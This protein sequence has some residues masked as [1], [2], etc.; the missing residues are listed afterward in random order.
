MK[1]WS[2]FK[3]TTLRETLKE[4]K[5]KKIIQEGWE[6]QNRY[7][8]DIYRFQHHL[9]NVSETAVKKILEIT[10]DFRLKW[11]VSSN[12]PL[13]DNPYKLASYLRSIYSFSR[14]QNHREHHHLWERLKFLDYWRG[15]IPAM[16]PEVLHHQDCLGT[17]QLLLL[18]TS[19]CRRVRETL[20][21]HKNP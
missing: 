9:F 13:D 19:Y 7:F 17:Q 6:E 16:K 12:Q 18:K 2:T 3:T 5:S 8:E 21:W 15:N 11:E 4:K 20:K 14:L 10:R 1:K